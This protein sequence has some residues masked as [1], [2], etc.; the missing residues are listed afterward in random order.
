MDAVIR[1]HPLRDPIAVLAVS[2]VTPVPIG[3]GDPGLFARHEALRR[4]K[5]FALAMH[6]RRARV[7]AIDHPEPRVFEQHPAQATGETLCLAVA[8]YHDGLT[9]RQVL[10]KR[11][12]HAEPEYE[13]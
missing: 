10:G 5:P 6:Q 2:G 7:S 3:D 1:A 11:P 9:H 13:Y 8:E 4:G 12:G